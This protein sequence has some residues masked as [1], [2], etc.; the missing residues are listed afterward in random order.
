MSVVI[1]YMDEYYKFYKLINRNIMVIKKY[2][3]YWEACY[4]C[5]HPVWMTLMLFKKALC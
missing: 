2:F 5:F 3:L 1:V 4:L